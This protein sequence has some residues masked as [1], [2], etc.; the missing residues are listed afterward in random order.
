MRFGRLVALVLLLVGCQADP[1]IDVDPTDNGAL[2]QDIDATATIDI[3]EVE[4]WEYRPFYGEI[5]FLI[6]EENTDTPIPDATFRVSD[7]P[8]KELENEV[9]VKSDQEG[10]MVIHQ[11]E[12]GIMYWGKGPPPPL[13]TFSAPGYH[14]RTYSVK[15]MASG[16]SYDPYRS[17]K[18]PTT[19]FTNEVG[20]EIELPFYEFTIRLAPTD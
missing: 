13:F 10:R 6:M 12:R 19:T 15:D 4:T 7:L 11:L 14:T 2:T 16:T 5:R 8:I 9:S 20:S 1:T 17:A 3:I 18:V